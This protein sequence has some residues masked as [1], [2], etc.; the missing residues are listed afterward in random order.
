MSV[1]ANVLNLKPE[2]PETPALPAEVGAD[3]FGP[4]E[5]HWEAFHP[6]SQAAH[7]RRY[8]VM[9]ALGVLGAGVAWWQASILTAL[10]V[11]LG[12]ATWEI[13]ER[14]T[15]PVAAHADERGLTIDGIHYPA[16]KLSSFDILSMPDG[17]NELSVATTLW[18]ARRLRVPLGQQNPDDVRAVLSRVVPEEQ[19]DAPLLDWWLRKS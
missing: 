13:K 2:E 19:H 5:A 10:V 7:V 11:L 16:A 6:L 4:E 17:T 8:M 9:G 14:I 18:H 15:R 3:L 12:L 1:M